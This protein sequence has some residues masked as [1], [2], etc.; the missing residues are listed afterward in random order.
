MKLQIFDTHKKSTG[1]KKLP[2]QF[3]EEYRPDLIR[4]AVRALRSAARQPYGA[5]TD[6][7]FRHSHHVSK[8]RRDWKT[9]Y[10]YGISRV[11]R[12]VLSHRGTRMFWV[13]TF[14]PQTVGGRRAHPPKAVKV[15]VQKIN[16]KE[17]RKAIRS[18]MAATLNS[19]V[20]T[21]RGHHLPKEYP[22]LI[23]GAFEQLQKTLDIEQALH[24][25]GFENELERS[26]VKK[27]R[28]GKG[29][30][31]GRRYQKK[32]GLVIIVSGDCPLLKAARNLPG[33]DVIVANSVN[34]EIL[35]PGGVPGRVAL[36]TDKA[37]DIIEK[38]HL[39]A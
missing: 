3:G 10:G 16:V 14:S 33:T 21:E 12:K 5:S 37:I 31:R 2:D 27:V 8:R 11:A 15:W 17:N 24:T 7:G 36:W 23:A 4:R 13:G 6:A 25:L 20:V 38:E 1:D 9:S 34:A 18:A 32:K 19:K 29:K 26:S 39:F 22:F 30:Y 35:A 28:A